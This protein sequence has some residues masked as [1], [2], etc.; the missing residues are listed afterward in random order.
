MPAANKA[1]LVEN[2]VHQDTVAPRCRVRHMACKECTSA[3]KTAPE[4]PTSC[5]TSAIARHA[6]TKHHG[7]W[8]IGSQAVGEAARASGGVEIGYSGDE[9]Y[10]LPQNH[11][12]LDITNTKSSGV[13]YPKGA[14]GGEGYL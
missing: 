13:V 6:G 8:A 11:A 12:G 9:S 3:G 7:L 2:L 10:H 14:A 4:L 5:D 1:A